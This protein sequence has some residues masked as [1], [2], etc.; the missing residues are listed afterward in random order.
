MKKTLKKII[1]ALFAIILVL[2]AVSCGDKDDFVPA[3]YK[4]ASNKNADYTLYV[5]EGWIVDM[6]TGVTTARV[7]KSD[8][9]NISFMGF[10]LDEAL[11]NSE[12]E[13]GATEEK[14]KL[15]KFWDYYAEEFAKTF[16]DMKYDEASV[17]D[18]KVTGT[19]MLI[20]KKYKAKEYIYT[21]TVTGAEYKFMQ[22]V[23]IKGE[24][25]Y[26]LTYTAKADSFDEYY[27][28]AKEIAGY[29]DIE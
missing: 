8:P 3:G 7:S 16:P 6:S 14:S 13:E 4:K 11:L 12:T 25:V 17:K 1:I 29:L 19:D 10:E 24:T 5:P 9:T 18:G 20:S 22:I 28:T 23:V 27:E 21:A 2:G 15:D 26:L